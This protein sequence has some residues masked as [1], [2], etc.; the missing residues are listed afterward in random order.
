M[1]A[2]EYEMVEAS[3]YGNETDAEY[4]GGNEPDKHSLRSISQ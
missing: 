4:I 3:K 2:S 1:S